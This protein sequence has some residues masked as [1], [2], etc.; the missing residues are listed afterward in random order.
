M[1]TGVRK[2]KVMVEPVDATHYRIS[3]PDDPDGWIVCGRSQDEALKLFERFSMYEIN[4]ADII[5]K[6]NVMGRI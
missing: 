4:T 5:A 2:V 3:L 6:D 1:E